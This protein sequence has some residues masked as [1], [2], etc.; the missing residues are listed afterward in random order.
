MMFKFYRRHENQIVRH[1]FWL[2]V[3]HLTQPLTVR[4]ALLPPSHQQ[5]T[6]TNLQTPK[7]WIAWLARAHVYNLF[8]LIARLN[9]KARAGI[10]LGGWSQYQTRWQRADSAV[11]DTPRN[12]SPCERGTEV[13]NLELIAPAASSISTGPS[14]PHKGVNISDKYS[15]KCLIG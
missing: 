14:R 10:E 5:I 12:K 6:G 15:V 13:F 4:R 7:I 1:L 3:S 11:R 8:R 2:T 9:Q